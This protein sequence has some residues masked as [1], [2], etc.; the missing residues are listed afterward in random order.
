MRGSSI[1]HCPS[2]ASGAM[3]T[4]FS[5]SGRLCVGWS[6]E[7]TELNARTSRF[8]PRCARGTRPS[9]S[10]MNA[11]RIRPLTSLDGVDPL[12]V[13][14][15]RQ[16]FAFMRRF[17]E[18][19]ASGA[20]RFD[21]PGECVLGAFSAG[22]LLGVAGLNRDPYVDVE[23]V[24]RLRHL[25]VL[26]SA[27]RLGVGTL[28][29]RRILQEARSSFHVV[30]LRTTTASAFYLRLG[31]SGVDEETAS[32]LMPVASGATKDRSLERPAPRKAGR[33]GQD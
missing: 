8:R 24:G 31:F 7:P 26:A 22:Q 3:S 17:V 32:H 1:G 5:V 15:E 23:G 6:G 25:Y 14:A 28:L 16:G 4:A 18:E 9:S 20:N 21:G 33:Q 30:R 12:V 11:I 13:E 10:F 19:W 29:V 2:G 27:R